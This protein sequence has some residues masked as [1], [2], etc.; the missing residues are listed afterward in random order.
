MFPTGE[1][2]QA[3]GMSCLL[4]ISGRLI[5]LTPME[6]G[7]DVFGPAGGGLFNPFA[8]YRAHFETMTTASSGD[9]YVFECRMPVDEEMTVERVCIETPASICDRSISESRN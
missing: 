3:M 8:D 6:S 5:R 1:C 2:S 4:L 9:C 7:R